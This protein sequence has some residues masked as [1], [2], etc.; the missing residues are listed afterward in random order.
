MGLAE[1]ADEVVRPIREGA[2]RVLEGSHR[3]HV[4]H[5][6]APSAPSQEERC[7]AAC[8]GDMVVSGYTL[9]VWDCIKAALGDDKTEG[10]A[11]S[12]VKTRD[13]SKWKSAVNSL[14]S[15][16]ELVDAEK[17]TNMQAH[18]SARINLW[19]GN[20]INMASPAEL[21]SYCS[22]D[23]YIKI[24]QF[25]KLKGD[26]PT[27]LAKSLYEKAVEKFKNVDLN[28][29]YKNNSLWALA[30]KATA[31]KGLAEA[32]IKKAQ[33]CI[34]YSQPEK[35]PQYL[36]LAEDNLLTACKIYDGEINVIAKLNNKSFANGELYIP[37]DYASALADFGTICLIRIDLDPKSQSLDA[38]KLADER[39]EKAYA[40]VYAKIPN[41]EM[42][43]KVAAA[44]ML[45]TRARLALEA[46]YKVEKDKAA[47]YIDQAEK[48]YAQALDIYG[49][50]DK[51][52]QEYMREAKAA[53][54]K[55]Y[56]QVVYAKYVNDYY[57]RDQEKQRLHFTPH[58]NLWP[59]ITI[60]EYT[61]HF[62]QDLQ[63]IGFMIE[64]RNLLIKSAKS[65]L[66]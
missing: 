9:N 38:V 10:A 37:A 64:F 15:A 21:R 5:H 59:K 13:I 17:N 23:D 39:L 11:Q 32:C 20:L 19:L 47:P 54:L 1:R 41:P 66:L 51:L 52:S 53:A 61:S 58:I 33:D 22:T 8:D 30:E 36:K 3:S 35:A 65:A 29:L 62:Q 6:H 49:P 14:L 46:S 43:V 40:M 34:K 48:L 44:G 24:A 16:A 28:A 4:S 60:M 50:M 27:L 42:S 55:D 31:Y 63:A 56:A 18:L 7:E 12:W 45:C 25:A 26:D 2:D 57:S